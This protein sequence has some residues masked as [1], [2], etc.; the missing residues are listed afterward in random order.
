MMEDQARKDDVQDVAM[1]YGHQQS[2]GLDDA[3]GQFEFAEGDDNLA[4]VVEGAYVHN[5]GRTPLHRPL[6]CVCHHVPCHD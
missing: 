2:S 1:V 6:A 4:D 3:H 5:Y